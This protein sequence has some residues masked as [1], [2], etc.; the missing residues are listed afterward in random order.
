LTVPTFC[1]FVIY[2]KP[3]DAAATWTTKDATNPD[4]AQAGFEWQNPSA[5]VLAVYH[6]KDDPGRYGGKDLSIARNAVAATLG[7]AYNKEH[8]RPKTN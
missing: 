8:A 2:Y 6:E 3:V 5:I 4:S 1:T 7:D